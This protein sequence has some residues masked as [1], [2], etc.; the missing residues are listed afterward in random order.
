[1]RTRAATYMRFLAV[2]AVLGSLG[3]AASIY[4]LV[5]ERVSLPFRDV[6]TVNVEFS[7]ADGVIDGIGQPVNVA[8]VKV[9]Q[10]AA[11]DLHDGRARVKLELERDQV[12]Q[13]YENATAVLEP[14][15]PLEDMQIALDPGAPPARPLAQGAAIPISRTRPPV[16]VSD[17]LARLDTD[18]RDYLSTLIS[19][20]GEGTAGRASDIRRMLRALGPTTAQVGRLNRAL[21]ARRTELARLVTNLAGVTRAA[22]R[23]GQLDDVVASGSATLAAIARE[24]APLRD[25]IRKLPPTLAT[26]RSTLRRLEPFARELGPTLSRLLPAVDRLP[27]VLRQLDPFAALG[28]Q[29]LRMDVRP[30]VRDAQPLTGSLSYAVPDLAR[31]TPDLTSG[32]RSINYFLNELA[33]NPPANDDEGFLFWGPWAGHNINS[34]FS[35]ADAHGNLSRAVPFVNCASARSVPQFA[36]LLDAADMCPG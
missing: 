10:I 20:L 4:V 31:S 35:A 15:T 34:L 25:A 32:S 16:P 36:G 12:P 21:D 28:E 6:H 19:S 22:S 26:T 8:G 5:H 3:T 27:A 1:M 24:E 14:I 23:D 33:Y 18:T 9:G 7:E 13:V 29:T 11:V 17:L 30:L 2:F